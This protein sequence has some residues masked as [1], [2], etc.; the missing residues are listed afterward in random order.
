LRKYEIKGILGKSTN[1]FTDEGNILEK[2]RFKHLTKSRLDTYLNQLEGASR[3]LM[4]KTIGVPVDSQ[5][6]YEIASKGMIRPSSRKTMPLLYS[7][8]CVHFEPPHFTLDVNV[9]N[10]NILYLKQLVHYIGLS[11]KTNACVSAIRCTRYG[12]FTVDHA[13]L[14][15]HWLAEHIVNNIN[16]CKPLCTSQNLY[17]SSANL[18][19]PTFNDIY[20]QDRVDDY[21]QAE[22]MTDEDEKINWNCE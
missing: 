5:A 1:D 18:L 20:S 2:S 14:E 13:L 10:E 22:R 16:D 19:P 8:K 17:P 12:P 11:V 6:A 7:I 3:T 4:F 9:I 21:S 15:K